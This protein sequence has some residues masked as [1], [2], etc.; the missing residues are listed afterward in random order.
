M[1]G[2]STYWPATA[3]E[4]AQENS[5]FVRDLLKKKEPEFA[6]MLELIAW[7]LAEEFTMASV[8]PVGGTVVAGLGQAG[9]YR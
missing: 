1:A 6:G 7:E 8:A 5:A 4:R 2:E 3:S 9:L